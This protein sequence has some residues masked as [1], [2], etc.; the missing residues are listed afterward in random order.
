MKAAHIQKDFL[1]QSSDKSVTRITKK[2]LQLELK[3][4]KEQVRI[5]AN[6]FIILFREEWATIG[7]YEATLTINWMQKILKQ[8][9]SQRDIKEKQLSVRMVNEN[10]CKPSSLNSEEKSSTHRV[11][12]G[13]Y[14]LSKAGETSSL[15]T[16]TLSGKELFLTVFYMQEI[17]W[18]QNQE[19][20]KTP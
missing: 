20:E 18:S 12:T 11:D 19:F 2:T 16:R 1:H 17:H 6:I 7:H 14:G 5:S 9:A 4:I 3:K 15:S 8:T 13:L 10:S